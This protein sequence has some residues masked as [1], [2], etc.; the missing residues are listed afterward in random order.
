MTKIT[1]S[2]IWRTLRSKALV[3][4]GLFVILLAMFS[5]YLRAFHR[6]PVPNTEGNGNIIGSIPGFSD[7]TTDGVA[8]YSIPLQVPPGRSGLQPELTLSYGSRGVNGI[9]GVGWTLE[10]LSLISGVTRITRWMGMQL[11]S[12]MT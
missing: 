6:K 7:V 11:H 4:V 3:A 5:F 2:R 8:R 10:G 12:L 1:G 9:L